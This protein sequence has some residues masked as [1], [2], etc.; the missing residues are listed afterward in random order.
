ME[1]PKF[2]FQATENLIEK[3]WG[4][5]WIALLKGFRR[6]GIGE[7]WEFSAHPSNPSKVLLKGEAVKLTE[8]FAEKKEEILGSLV[9]KHKTFPIL[10]KIVEIVGKRVP[11]V[12]PSEKIAESL[13]LDDGGKLKI[14]IMVSGTSYIGFSDDVRSEDVEV[15]LTEEKVWEKMNKFIAST[16]DSFI[17]PCGTIHSAE[18]AKFVEIGTNAEAAIEL[19]DERIKK[20]INLKKI[21]DFEIRVKKGRIETEPFVAEILEIIGK[22][23]FMIDTFNILLNLEGYAILRSEKEVVDLQRGYSCLVPAKTASYS[24]QSEKAKVLRVYPR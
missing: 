1:L 2:I 8:L 18:N 17:I 16:Y 13:G 23:D 19:R 11:I 22:Q 7:S 24:V 5:E 10:L 3:P 4:G 12:H 9:D 20:A 15:V 21:E 6:K 14:W